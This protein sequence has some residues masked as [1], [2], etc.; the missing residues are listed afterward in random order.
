MVR[1]RGTSTTSPFGSSCFFANLA[2]FYLGGVAR[3]AYTL[4]PGDDAPALAK[5]IAAAALLLWIGASRP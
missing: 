2:V 4:G 5:L 1:R 3:K